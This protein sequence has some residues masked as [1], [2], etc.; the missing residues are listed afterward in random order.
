MSA[1]RPDG[2]R[3]RGLLVPSPVDVLL[4]TAI[5]APIAVHFPDYDSWW[6]LRAG[7]LFLDLGGL[8][9]T[10]PFSFSASGRE[11]FSHEWIPEMMMAALAERC[12]DALLWLKSIVCF[13]TA[14]LVWL[15]LGR[16][17]RALPMARLVV[18]LVAFSSLIPTF[19]PRPWM[20]SFMLLALLVYAWGARHGSP[21]R[22]AVGLGVLLAAWMNLHGMYVVGFVWLLLQ[23]GGAV[24]DWLAG[25]PVDREWDVTRPLLAMVIGCAGALAHPFG[26]RILAYPF[27]YQF[28]E[29]TRSI[30]EWMPPDMASSY[31]RFLL[32][33]TV[34]TLLLFARTRP[35]GA[36]WVTFVA[37]GYLA[38]NARRNIPVLCLGMVPF[39]GDA[40]AAAVGGSERAV[41]SR[42][43]LGSVARFAWRRFDNFNVVA[44]AEARSRFFVVALVAM[45]FVL[46]WLS[47]ATGS[48]D[49]L[50]KLEAFPKLYPVAATAWLLEQPAVEQRRIFNF[51]GWGGYLVY[52][53]YPSIRTFID[54]RTDLFG[55]AIVRDYNT[56]AG[57]R[58]E[59]RA[60]LRRH[61]I[62][63][64]LF[65]VGDPLCQLLSLDPSW[66]EAY[67]D[68][69]A[70]VFLRGPSSGP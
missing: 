45:S 14:G 30:L 47:P 31:G 48:G 56:V 28:G 26:W 25:L 59:W 63:G 49:E 34:A 62:D 50:Y 8:P 16:S 20:F 18:G 57:L 4:V 64:V 44:L 54:G 11:W 36:A 42:G 13:A 15:T 46:L 7:R 60:V 22:S 41:A 70:V 33:S 61:A 23:I 12:L 53:G 40:V 68:G 37:L 21:R 1:A 51:Y 58:P 6:H 65:P 27:E 9:A 2:S 43:W 17:L 10:D 52:A 35:R 66:R 5:F 38:F 3:W 24:V 19:T 29:I 67:R 69:T 32:L 39:W 55:P